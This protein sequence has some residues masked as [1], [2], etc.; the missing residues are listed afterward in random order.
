MAV[1]IAFAAGVDTGD[2]FTDNWFMSLAG[3]AIL[4]SAA[5]SVVTGSVALIRGHDR[6]WLVL[7]GT[8]LSLLVT[9]LMLQQVAEGLGWLAG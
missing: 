9:A 3:V 5:V 4:A 1:A 2:S 8:G 7:A 6:S